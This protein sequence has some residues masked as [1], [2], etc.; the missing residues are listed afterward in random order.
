MFA[1]PLQTCPGAN[2]QLHTHEKQDTGKLSFNPYLFNR[3]FRHYKLKIDC[4]KLTIPRFPFNLPCGDIGFLKKSI[5]QVL[6]WKSG[7]KDSLLPLGLSCPL[8]TIL[9][10]DLAGCGSLLQIVWAF[11][12][13]FKKFES[14]KTGIIVLCRL[15]HPTQQVQ[16]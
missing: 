16:I 10:S 14:C 6:T 9:L 12:T 8:Q 15:P 11:G 4:L 3:V 2:R 7:L 13:L 1:W 5:G